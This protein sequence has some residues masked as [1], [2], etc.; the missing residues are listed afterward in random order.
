MQM[1]MLQVHKLNINTSADKVERLRD[2]EN[3]QRQIKRQIEAL[4]VGDIEIVDNEKAVRDF[5]TIILCLAA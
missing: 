2:L 1:L 5:K 3:Q 4:E